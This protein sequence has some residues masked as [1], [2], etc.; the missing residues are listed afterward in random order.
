MNI[1][2]IR[3]YFIRSQY[4]HDLGGEDDMVIFFISCLMKKLTG[5]PNLSETVILAPWW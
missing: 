1:L 2:F 4:S 3:V 5:K